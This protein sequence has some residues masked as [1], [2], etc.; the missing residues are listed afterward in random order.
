[1]I[2]EAFDEC[3][4]G[5][6]SILENTRGWSNVVIWTKSFP[7][8][9]ESKYKGREVEVCL[10]CSLISKKSSKAGRKEREKFYSE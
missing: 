6:E 2:S 8:Q 7:G 3:E 10:M 9:D 5:F 4:T 1:M